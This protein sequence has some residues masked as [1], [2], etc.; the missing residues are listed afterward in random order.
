MKPDLNQLRD[1]LI[2]VSNELVPDEYGFVFVNPFLRNYIK[3]T[4]EP[5]EKMLTF[6]H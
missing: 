3:K 1:I 5:F 6:L 4:I 2:A